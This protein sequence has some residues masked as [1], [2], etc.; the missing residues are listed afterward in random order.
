MLLPFFVS[1]RGV[2]LQIENNLRVNSE[3][4]TGL[5]MKIPITNIMTPG[6]KTEIC[7]FS[8]ETP[9]E[10]PTIVIK[11]HGVAFQKRA[12]LIGSESL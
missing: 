9:A 7:H 5:T 10:T 8:G 2:N 1:L 4:L 12:V 11:V 6:S 3:I